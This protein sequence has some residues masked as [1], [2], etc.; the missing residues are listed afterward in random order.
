[1]RGQICEREA[2]Y[3]LKTGLLLAR[4]LSRHS[5]LPLPP[6]GPASEAH[7]RFSCLNKFR[8]GDSAISD[9]GTEPHLCRRIKLL[10]GLSMRMLNTLI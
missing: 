2:R 9:P 3:Q 4:C 10:T 7:G 8:D 6:R 5:S 1:M